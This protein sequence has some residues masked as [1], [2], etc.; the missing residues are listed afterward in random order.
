MSS[1]EPTK[2]YVYQPFGSATHPVH[3]R[4]GR[5]WGVGGVSGLTTISGLTK[6]EAIEIATA[7]QLL[8]DVKP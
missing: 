2:P 5:L 7:I 6:V 1:Q 3:N 8:R 4:E